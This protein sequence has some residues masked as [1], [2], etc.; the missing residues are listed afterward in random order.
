MTIYG[1][2]NNSLGKYVTCRQ[3]IQV[4][5]TDS[6]GPQ[7][8]PWMSSEHWVKTKPWTPLSLAPKPRN[9]FY[10]VYASKLF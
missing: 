8:L 3:P 6:D 5:F 2:I 1:Q 4:E 7:D 9:K 10:V